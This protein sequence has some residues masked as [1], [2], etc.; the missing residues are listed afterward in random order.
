MRNVANSNRLVVGHIFHALFA[1]AMLAVSGAASAESAGSGDW[2]QWHGP[3]RDAVC[4]ETG[5]LKQW[6][7]EGPKLEWEL[8]GLGPG[9]SSIVIT[10]GKLLTMGNVEGQSILAYSLAD[11]KLLWKAKVGPASDQPHCTPTV[12]G[13]RVYAIG[14]A[15]DLVCVSL[16]DGKELWRKSLI[17]DFGAKVPGWNFS[18]SPLVD[19]DKLVC[20]PAGD[21][22]LMVALNKTSG[23]VIWKCAPPDPK[24]TGAVGH[25][26][27]VVSKGAGVPQYVTL[28]SGAAIGVSAADGKFLWAYPRIANG[29][30]NIPTPVVQGD[31]VFVSTAYNTGAALLKLAKAGEGIKAE[32]VYF[33]NANTFQCHHGGFL[34]V[35]DYIFGAHGHNSGNPICIEMATG[36]VLWSEK[37]LGKG[38]GAVLFA[39]GNLYYRYEDDTV[40]LIEANPKSYILK[41]SFKVPGRPGMGGPGWAHPVIHDGKLYIRHADVLFCYDIKAK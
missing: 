33:L 19:G 2:N 28:T 11:R 38:S 31:F 6:P 15:G 12:D 14:T 1:A 16:V 25:A 13:D 30:A 4:K 35:G 8:R 26:S 41:G 23:E 10:G 37:Q 29:T 40:A 20:T 5:L 21:V 24:R 9:F 7:A 17:R 18:E 36:K 34:R 27:I 3:N 39:D 22:A 32:E